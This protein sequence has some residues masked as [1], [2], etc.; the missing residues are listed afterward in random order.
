MVDVK[1]PAVPVMAGIH[2]FPVGL[3]A[4]VCAPLRQGSGK[5]IGELEFPLIHLAQ[6]PGITAVG[7]AAEFLD[8]VSPPAFRV[9]DGGRGSNGRSG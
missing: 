5:L 4:G 2:R 3:T 7:K 8:G 1:R 6:G 9:P